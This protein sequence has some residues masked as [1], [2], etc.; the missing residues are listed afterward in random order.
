MEI[1]SVSIS[2]FKEHT[3]EIYEAY[4]ETWKEYSKEFVEA[5]DVKYYWGYQE[6]EDGVYYFSVNMFPSAEKR[7]AWGATYDA[8]GG[9]KEFNKLFEEKI[10][11]SAEEAEEGKEMEINLYGMA[12]SLTNE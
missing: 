6:Q 8:E 10:G 9:Q 3:A 7:D 5:T 1:M 12:I 4:K 2:K 11:M